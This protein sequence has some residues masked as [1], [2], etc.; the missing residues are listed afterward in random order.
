M[1]DLTAWLAKQLKD[2]NLSMRELERRSG[3]SNV[4]ISRVLSGKQAIT[5]D[6]CKAIARALDEPLVNVF[7]MAGLLDDLPASSIV[8]PPLREFVETFTCLSDSNREEI[9]A[10]MKLK[11]EMQRGKGGKKG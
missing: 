1:E 9:L 10:L 7:F 2:H 8:P 6:F 4:S 5:A 3:V 11:L